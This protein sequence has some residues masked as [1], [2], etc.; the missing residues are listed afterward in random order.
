MEKLGLDWKHIAGV[1]LGA[2][3]AFGLKF[4]SDKGVVIPCPSAVI[5]AEQGK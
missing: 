2:A 4:A 5:S 1:I 3:L